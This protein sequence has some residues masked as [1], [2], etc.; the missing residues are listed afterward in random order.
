MSPR[1]EPIG[2]AVAAVRI[3]ALRCVAAF[4]RVHV[5]R[6]RRRRACDV[7]ECS[8]GVQSESESESERPDLRLVL[9]RV[10]ASL[11]PQ[12]RE[13]AV[14]A[15]SA[16][17]R[18]SSAASTASSTRRTH[19][20]FHSFIHLSVCASASVRRSGSGAHSRRAVEGLSL[21]A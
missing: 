2:E 11:A 12:P 17:W 5:P 6:A 13:R 19:A 16:T 14:L 21:R 8:A 1:A 18:R 3:V 9:P 7:A 15:H 20:F 10:G 4:A